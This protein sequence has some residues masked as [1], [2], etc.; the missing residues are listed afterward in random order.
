MLLITNNITANINAAKN[1]AF[2]L[3]FLTH[4]NFFP[5]KYNGTERTISTKII[6]PT[7]ITPSTKFFNVQEP[8]IKQRIHP[9]NE[10]AIITFRINVGKES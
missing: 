3:F 10:N 2:V 7:P 9:V 4:S 6:V 8:L 5:R 1:N